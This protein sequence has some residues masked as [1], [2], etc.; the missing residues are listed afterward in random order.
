ME[1]Q[2]FSVLILKVSNT[3][4]VAPEGYLKNRKWRVA[5]TTNLKEALGFLAQ[6]SPQYIL[7]PVDHPNKK[8]LSL[9]QLIKQAFPKTRIIPYADKSSSPATRSLQ[10]LNMEYNLYPPV[11]GPAIQRLI[12]KIVKDDETRASID[13]G[14]ANFGEKSSENSGDGVLKFKGEHGAS[15]NP[16]MSF[17]QA[18]DALSRM[19]QSDSDD[20]SQIGI[21]GAVQQGSASGEFSFQQQGI[22]PGKDHSANQQGTP[23]GL[24]YSA[25]ET[26]PNSNEFSQTQ[27]G[28]GAKGLDYSENQE[29]PAAGEFS[30]GQS[31]K[32]SPGGPEYSNDEESTK[33]SASYRKKAKPTPHL[34]Y[35][36]SDDDSNPNASSSST[37]AKGSTE[38]Q[39]ISE[40]DDLW[41]KA[42]EESAN[43]SSKRR[44]GLV[45]PIMESEYSPKKKKVHRI[46]SDYQNEDLSNHSI[47]VRGTQEALNKSSTIKGSLED[48]ELNPIEN[49]S[50]VACIL[51]E[52]QRYRGYLVCAL[53]KNKKVDKEFINSV[54]KSLFQ[55]LKSQGE[56]LNDKKDVL[57]LSLT[58]VDFEPWALSQAD[59]LRKSIHGDDEVAIAFFP[60][61]LSDPEL[62]ESAS[63]QMLQLSLDELKEDTK[64]EF[65][66]YIYMPENK[67]YLLYTPQGMTF[68]TDQKGRLKD[69]GV[70]HM[71]L[72][73]DS[74]PQVKKYRAQNFLNEKINEFNKKKK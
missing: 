54:Q 50:H 13:T 32:K 17:E 25:N 53:G 21:Q 43:S 29:G 10:E 72:K 35:S 71:H 31:K 63:K 14:E 11:S 52:S 30:I 38:I 3:S 7:I 16:S 37:K 27:K 61:P 40:D 62:E 5:S 47:I 58:E 41:Q 51:V 66:L 23:Q 49:S 33:E 55:F 69:K 59:F 20:G 65:D 22:A 68:Y 28:H 1:D 8:T 39:G 36:D 73:K 19:I 26:G 42:S 64:V 2:I 4:M 18:R 45:A 6:K 24:D 56:N 34:E 9:L 67:K 12:L 15:G 70:R 74:A 57:H 44:D 48:T 60:T 46:V